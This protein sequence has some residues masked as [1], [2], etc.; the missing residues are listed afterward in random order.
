M[1]GKA[2]S[3]PRCAAIVGPYLSGKTSLLEALLYTCEAIPRLGTI[4]DGN[5]VGDSSDDARARQMSTELNIAS[6]TFLDEEWT[7]VDCPGSVEFIQESRAALMAADVAI[8]VCEPETS[9]ALMLAPV[10]QFL[11]AHDIPRML[12]INKVDHS[13]ETVRD[14]LAALQDVSSKP[15]VLRQVPIRDGDAVTGYVDLVSERAYEYEPGTAS[16]LIEVPES[17]SDRNEEARQEMLESLADFDDDLLEQ[18]LEDNVPPSEKVYALLGADLQNDLITPVFLGAAE[19]DHGVLRLM[20]ALRHEAPEVIQTLERHG[21]AD[22]DTVVQVF[23]TYHMLHAGK[24]SVGRVWKGEIKDGMS[25]GNHRVSG[26]NLLKGHEA[27][28]ITS[29]IAGSVVAMGRMDDVHTGHTLS[30]AGATDSM[31]W[32]ETPAPIFSM[33]AIPD[34]R[35]DE[36]K[37]STGIARLME[38]DPSISMSHNDDTNQNVL[39]GQGEIQLQVLGQRLKNRFNTAVTM[40]RPRTPYKETIKK[41]IQQHARHKKQSGGHGEFGDVH[42]DIKP[43]PRGSSFEFSQSISGGVVPRQY[44]PAVEAGVKEYCTEGPLGFP[45]VDLSVNLFDGQHHAVDSSDMAFRRAGILAMKDALPNCS[46]VLLEPIC[47]VNIA[48]PNQYTS[49]AQSII[50]KRRGQILSF[51]AKDGWTGWDEVQANIP[52]S[53]LH[54]LAIDL[55]SQTMGIGSFE[56]SFDHMAELAG[57]A[58]DDVIEQ[59]KAAAE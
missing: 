22:G 11:D 9:K 49:N 13:S 42:L 52:Q 28:R 17:V 3:G 14:L 53:E 30:E 51:Q 18:L 29:A 56:W 6:A 59:H 20:K 41:A 4:K 26:M 23:K 15:L 10:M 47:N 54:D 7:F 35:D 27:K 39:W 37:L 2:P 45:V 46:P 19:R 31:D 5:T 36:V 48:I 57:R 40:H 34:K 33:V 21:G 38:E 1:S 12:F 24:M 58:A 50:T 32:P 16:K 43:Q 55:R 25:F 44:I 8:V